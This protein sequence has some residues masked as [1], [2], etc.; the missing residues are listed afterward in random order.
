MRPDGTEESGLPLDEYRQVFLR[1]D[2]GLFAAALE[3]SRSLSVDPPNRL[4][5]QELFRTVHTIKGNAMALGFER[6]AS[7][8]HGLEDALSDILSGKTVL[9]AARS[10][11][12]VESV[13]SLLSIVEECQRVVATTTAV[14][15]S[16]APSAVLCLSARSDGRDFL[17]PCSAIT[18]LVKSPHVMLLPGGREGWLGVIRVSM[19]LVPL[20][21]PKSFTGAEDS[22]PSRQL[23]AEPFLAVVLAA[24]SKNPD[25]R[26]LFSIPVESVGAVVEATAGASCPVID[27]SG[28]AR[29]P[30]A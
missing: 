21:D 20:L 5:Q 11:T 24:T 23:L 10:R 28:I 14:M 4:A 25:A 8:A 13:G 7:A 19:D 22:R 18:E 12:I 15:P 16:A 1:D 17:I 29:K 9:D 27:I 26:T 2:A 30:L 6:I 3:Q